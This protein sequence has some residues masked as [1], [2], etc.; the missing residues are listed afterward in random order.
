MAG[1]EK[2]HTV[3]SLYAMCE[4]VGECWEWGGYYGN[5]V[6][7]VYQG[8]RMRSV[9]KVMLQLSG[10]ELGKKSHFG[11]S[12]GNGRCVNP[13][14]VQART[15]E[16]Q[17]KH[18][19]KM[20]AGDLLRAAKIQRS[21]VGRTKLTREQVDEILVSN[22]K[23]SELVEKYGVSKAYIVKIKRGLVWRRFGGPWA[24]LF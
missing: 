8:G 16:Q 5:G 6:P 15:M 12:C 7:S 2:V 3:E 19:G 11:T 24:G 20:G 10:V 23:M 1:R 14:H 22:L 13:E 9:R 21:W 18:M 4:E 17:G